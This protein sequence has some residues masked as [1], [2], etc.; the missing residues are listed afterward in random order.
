V[1][2]VAGGVCKNEG[3]SGNLTGG[4]RTGDGEATSEGYVKHW[5]LLCIICQRSVNM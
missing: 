5:N 4:R 3:Q 1:R 2:N